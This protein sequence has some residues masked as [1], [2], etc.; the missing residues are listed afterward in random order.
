[1]TK[2]IFVVRLSKRHI[3]GV[4]NIQTELEKTLGKDYH[5]LVVC[6]EFHGDI[7]EF[8]CYNSEYTE[9]EFETLQKRVLSLIEDSLKLEK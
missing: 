7:I 5:V 6:D 1:M 2:P 9:I 3:D 8:E 4:K